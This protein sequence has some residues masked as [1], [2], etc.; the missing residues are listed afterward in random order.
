[1]CFTIVRVV[2]GISDETEKPESGADRAGQV[3]E[4]DTRGCV[5]GH[6]VPVWLGDSVHGALGLDQPRDLERLGESSPGTKFDSKEERGRVAG[7][8]PRRQ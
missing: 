5:G 7:H 8:T 4:G 3:G 2:G 6:Q 1:M